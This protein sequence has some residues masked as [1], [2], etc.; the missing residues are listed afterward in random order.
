ML[1]ACKISRGHVCSPKEQNRGIT[2]SYIASYPQVN[3][4]LKFWLVAVGRLDGYSFVIL[5]VYS[6]FRLVA[7]NFIDVLRFGILGNCMYKKKSLVIFLHFRTST[8]KLWRVFKFLCTPSRVIAIRNYG[9]WICR[10]RFGA[11][12]RDHGGFW[13]DGKCKRAEWKFFSRGERG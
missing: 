13:L 2:L 9:S 7:V 10:A 8:L 1:Y 5:S 4:K 11:L 6:P 12:T 3:H